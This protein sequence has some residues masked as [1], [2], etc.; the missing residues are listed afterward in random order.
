MSDTPKIWVGEFLDTGAVVFD[1]RCQSKY[2]PL[3]VVLW[4]VLSGKFDIR[5]KKAA[6]SEV[7]SVRDPVARNDALGRYAAFIRELLEANHRAWIGALKAKYF[8]VRVSRRS[9][10]AGVHCYICKKGL[11][12]TIGLE[13]VGCGWG[14]CECGACGCG[15]GKKGVGD[16]NFYSLSDYAR[17][18]GYRRW[19]ELPPRS[20]DPE[21]LCE[22]V[23][24]LPAKFKDGFCGSC[25]STV[26]NDW[27]VRI[28]GSLRELRH[29]AQ[30]PY[31]YVLRE[32]ELALLISALESGQVRGTRIRKC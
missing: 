12:G 2:S 11:D 24:E 23:G 5:E 22:W 9:R 20:T 14:L 19:R 10:A 26:S 31:D 29:Y 4:G 6:R 30:A 15:R 1:T 25:D 8:G 28:H 13:C 7:R 27:C 16:G 32:S 3:E 18:E 17:D 21:E